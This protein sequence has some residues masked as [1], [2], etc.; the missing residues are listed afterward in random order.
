M[1]K[2]VVGSSEK[3]NSGGAGYVR[4]SEASAR[5]V[6]S[7]VIASSRR[8][9]LATTPSGPF[10]WFLSHQKHSSTDHYIFDPDC[11][12]NLALQASFQRSLTSACSALDGESCEKA[13]QPRQVYMEDGEPFRGRAVMA[14][15]ES[16]QA[17]RSAFALLNYPIPAFPRAL[18]R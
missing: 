6:R 12:P 5:K 10:P 11:V 3:N 7:D 8:V 9:R 18:S 1:K 15:I 13:A 4:G 2:N 17:L 14:S 16:D